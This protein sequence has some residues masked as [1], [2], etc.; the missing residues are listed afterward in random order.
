MTIEVAGDVAR[1]IS[2]L[3]LFGTCLYFFGRDRGEKSILDKLDEARQAPD[4]DARYFV[5]IN[6]PV[7]ERG[8]DWREP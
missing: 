5:F 8:D 3:T 6:R 7:S 4:F 1:V 2:F